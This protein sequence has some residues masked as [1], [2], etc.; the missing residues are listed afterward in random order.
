MRTLVK[1]INWLEQ[2]FAAMRA[3]SSIIT[4]EQKVWIQFLSDAELEARILKLGGEATAHLSEAEAL[5]V[6][7]RW[8]RESGDTF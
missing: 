8:F 5:K 1:R 2:R 3:E 7:R 6:Y 4:S